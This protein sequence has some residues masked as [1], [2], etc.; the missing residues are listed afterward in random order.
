M[1]FLSIFSLLASFWGPTQDAIK[2][3]LSVSELL[4]TTLTALVGGGGVLGILVAIQAHLG[5]IVLDPQLG[6][7]AGVVLFFLI[8]CIRRFDHEAA[9]KPVPKS[10][11]HD[12]ERKF[13]F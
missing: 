2:K 12:H 4:R 10:D 3:Y 6:T 9:P 5:V 7:T 1:S 13:H 11:F 8:D